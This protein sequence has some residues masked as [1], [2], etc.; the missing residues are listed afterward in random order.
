M[1]AG[2]RCAPCADAVVAEWKANKVT[3]SRTK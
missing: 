3:K 2:Q 1:P